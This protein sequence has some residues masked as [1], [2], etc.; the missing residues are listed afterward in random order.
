MCPVLH[1][2]VRLLILLW[3]SSRFSE[4]VCCLRFFIFEVGDA[5][6]GVVVGNAVFK[7]HW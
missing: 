3:M 5:D 6:A 7:M 2:R 1:L 4:L